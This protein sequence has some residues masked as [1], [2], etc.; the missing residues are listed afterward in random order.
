MPVK[1]PFG[2][3]PKNTWAILIRLEAYVTYYIKHYIKHLQFFGTTLPC[4]SSVILFMIQNMDCGKLGFVC[5]NMVLR[6]IA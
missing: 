2:V 5:C 1:K 4:F 3:Y 6:L